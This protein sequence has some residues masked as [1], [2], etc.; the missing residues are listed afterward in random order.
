MLLPL[1][2]FGRGH[3]SS[4]GAT[5]GLSSSVFVAC[6]LLFEAVLH[7]QFGELL[8]FLRQGFGFGALLDKPA[9]APDVNYYF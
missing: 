8:K 3:R 2:V 5:A 9:V 4:Q 7:F 1:V 6:T